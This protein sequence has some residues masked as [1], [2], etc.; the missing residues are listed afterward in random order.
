MFIRKPWLKHT[1]KRYFLVRNLAAIDPSPWSR[2]RLVQDGQ[3]RVNYYIK[4]HGM[5]RSRDLYRRFWRV[6]YGCVSCPKRSFPDVSSVSGILYIYMSIF[7]GLLSTSYVIKLWSESNTWWK[8]MNPQLEGNCLDGCLF[9]KGGPYMTLLV[10]HGVC[11][12]RCCPRS[13]AGQK[14]WKKLIQLVFVESWRKD[15]KGRR[16]LK[17]VPLRSSTYTFSIPSGNLYHGHGTWPF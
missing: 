13:Q 1:I 3:R 15:T 2:S 9:P 14:T 12:P 6:I 16:R 5:V 4:Q 10:D 7:W 17:K 8:I 11:C